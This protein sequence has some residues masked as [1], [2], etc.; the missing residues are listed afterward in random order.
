MHRHF[1]DQGN[2]AAVKELRRCLEHPHQDP[3]FWTFCRIRFLLF[4]DAQAFWWPGQSCCGE[5]VEK[6]LRTPT[7]RSTLLD[8][9]S[10][11]FPPVFQRT[12]ILMTK[13]IMWRQKRR[14]KRTN[15]WTRKR[16]RSWAQRW[17]LFKSMCTCL[18]S[19]SNAWSVWRAKGTHEAFK[20]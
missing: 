13:V 3:P 6:L 19:E 20:E 1:N 5:R 7:P 8:L 11:T 4:F 12:G 18:K 16:Q 15:G 10:H 17:V 2:H 14:A 9:L